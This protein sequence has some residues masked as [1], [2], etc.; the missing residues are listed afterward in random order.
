MTCADDKRTVVVDVTTRTHNKAPFGVVTIKLDY[1]LERG[2][3][4]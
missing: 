2:G 1:A 4:E 3:L